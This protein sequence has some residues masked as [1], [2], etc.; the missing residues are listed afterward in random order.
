MLAYTTGD[1]HIEVIYVNLYLNIGILFKP[2]VLVYPYLVEYT[3]H[4]YSLRN[5]HYHWHKRKFC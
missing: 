2:L 1:L 4:L 5:F 3:Y